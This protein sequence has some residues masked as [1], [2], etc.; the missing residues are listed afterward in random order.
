MGTLEI[1][2]GWCARVGRDPRAIE[3]NLPV[4][5]DRFESVL[6]FLTETPSRRA[7]LRL[8][9]GSVL[10]GAF[11]VGVRP[12]RAKKG[13]GK[14]KRKKRV[15]APPVVSPSPP[16]PCAPQDPAVVCAAGCGTRPNNCGQKVTCPCPPG[17]NCLI[18]G[19]CGI[20]CTG[21]GTCPSAC[22]ACS[23]GN[24]EGQRLCIATG[25]C[26]SLPSCTIT[27]DCERGSQCQF[28][29]EESGRCVPL[30]AL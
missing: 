5:A 30:C 6:R 11:T 12:A 2:D 28:C 15:A 8:L 18:N 19:S 1:V 29:G 22:A 13:K 4:D 20:P 17:Q 24:K 7:A 26:A 21:F 16:A 14:K 23:F 3:R 27:S 25:S 9:A 10:G